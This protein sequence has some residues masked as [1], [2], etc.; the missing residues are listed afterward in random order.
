MPSASLVIA[1]RVLET[2]SST[3]TGTITLSGPVSGYRSFYTAIGVGN[4]TY[5]CIT[6]NTSGEWEVGLGNVSSS[7]SL[8]RNVV[9]SSSNSNLLVSFSSGGLQVFCTIP[10]I[11]STYI[12][13]TGVPAHFGNYLTTGSPTI[14]GYIEVKDVSGVTRKLAVIS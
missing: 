8:V 12:D 11:A 1:D 10:A 3:G 5:Y 2:S 14:T 4:D 9:Y 7:N 13:G 6:N